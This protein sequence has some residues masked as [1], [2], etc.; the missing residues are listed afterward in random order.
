MAG[1]T[2]TA[3][4]VCIPDMLLYT[5]IGGLFG[6]YDGRLDKTLIDTPSSNQVSNF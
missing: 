2:V 6:A 5:Y 3:I 4:N 1:L